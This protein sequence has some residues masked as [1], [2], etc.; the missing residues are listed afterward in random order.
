MAIQ[1]LSY[2]YDA[3]QR[4]FLEQIVHAFSG[5]S[6]MTGRKNG[7]EPQLRMVPCRMANRDRMVAQIM[8][9]G[10]ENAALTCPLITIDQTGLIARRNDL[11][12]T[13]HVDTQQVVERAVD[14]VTGEYTGE[15][16]N[17]YTVRRMMPLP[18]EMM[19]QVDVWTSNLDQKYQ[20]SEQILPVFY[21]DI[22]IQNGENALDWSARTSMSLE[23]ISWSSRSV[24]VGS[25]SEID[26]LTLQFKLPM[27]ISPPA[28]VTEQK[29]VQQIITNLRAGNN[30]TEVINNI[31]VDNTIAQHIVTPGNHRV[32]VDPTDGTIT[33][34]G[35]HGGELDDNGEVYRWDKLFDQYGSLRLMTSQIRLKRSDNIDNDSEIVGI[36]QPDN[37]RPNVLFWQI[38][39]D[40]LSANTLTPIVGV[41]DPMKTH[42]Q[43]GITPVEGDRYLITA[44]VGPSTAW[45]T[46]TAKE[47]DIIRY[48]SGSWVVDFISA[49]STGDQYLRNLFTGTQ[50][51]WTGKQWQLAIGGTYGPGYWRLFL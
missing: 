42:P 36:I 49:Q 9:N 10:S 38:D 3:Q 15:A 26:V 37:T 35:P 23:D 44:D 12:N 19:I 18:F 46:L 51:R 33:L 32:S 28:E 41:I 43:N 45:G 30:V 17:R 47:N 4:R 1:G 29:I 24:P 11:Q 8:R 20:L 22:Q 13:Q 6:Y 48:H 7:A 40:T 16:G 5:F 34:L 27:W 21:P 31:A 25:E 2:W 50:L 14:P 39:P